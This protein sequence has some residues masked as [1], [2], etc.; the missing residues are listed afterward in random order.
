[1]QKYMNKK[2]NSI[3]LLK[4]IGSPLINKKF[5]G[6]I[7]E[8]KE[9]FNYAFRNNIEMLYCQKLVDSNNLSILI[10]KFTELKKRVL[11]SQ[12]SVIKIS[13][14]LKKENII[15]AV[16]KTIRPYP[17]TP[18]DS[19]ILYL[20]DLENY[21]EATNIL[22][23][24]GYKITAPNAMQYELFD[25]SVEENY[26]D[27]K[28]GGRFYID[29]Y[30]EL[31]ADYM[32]YMDSNL[33]KNEIKN[34]EVLGENVC[35]LED[36]AEIIVLALH[37]VLMHRI[38]PMEVIYTYSYIF[39]KM[40]ESELNEIWKFVKLSHGEVAFRAVMTIMYV[41]YDKS[42]DYIPQ[43]ITFFINKIGLSKREKKE[44]IKNN[45]KMPHIITLRTFIYSVFSKIRGKR[46]RQG[47]FKELFHMLNPFFAIE[48]FYH[49]LSKNRIEE[50][51]DHV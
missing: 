37:S 12:K 13:K 2:F 7:I 6:K 33:L 34:I 27:K 4:I 16:T 50:H 49:M 17:A 42:F 26:N 47:F 5:T 22:V 9:L 46:A 35:V 21:Q 8:S 28:S 10:I 41:L 39:D 25:A 32:P 1:M 40:S 3:E 30:R 23:E 19:D 24:N 48:V 18:N 29:F 43:E 11:D 36:K 31:A 44:L 45:L 14:I 38:I 20:G 51:S 15:H